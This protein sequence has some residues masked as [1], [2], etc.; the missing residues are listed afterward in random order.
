MT[1][2]EAMRRLIRVCEGNTVRYINLDRVNVIAEYADSVIF[3]YADGATAECHGRLE[4][5]LDDDED[6]DEWYDCPDDDEGGEDDDTYGLFDW[7][8]ELAVADR[9]LSFSDAIDSL[10]MS[11]RAANA[12]KR[13]G[14][15]TVEQ[16]QQCSLESLTRAPGIGKKTAKEIEYAVERSRR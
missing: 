16:L 1:K 11:N 12:L 8:E 6:D 10:E 14:I 7:D 2:S 13:A 9:R 3:A 5:Y 15:Y 4:D